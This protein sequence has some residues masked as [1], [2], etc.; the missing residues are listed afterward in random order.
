MQLVGLSISAEKTGAVSARVPFYGTTVSEA[1]G[2]MSA[3]FLGLQR[4]GFDIRQEQDGKFV[5]TGTYEGVMDDTGGG[6]TY[7]SEERTVYD[8]SPSFEQADIRT[9]PKFSELLKKYYGTLDENEEVTWGKYI[10]QGTGSGG[11]LGGSGDSTNFI[12]NPMR[13]VREYY[14][15][16]GVWSQKRVYPNLPQ[17]VFSSVGKIIDNPPGDL[18]SIGTRFWLTLP[19]VVTQKG[20]QWEVTRRWMMSGEKSTGAKEAAKDIYEQFNG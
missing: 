10:P 8:W 13:G 12:D 16:G 7:D 4:T 3:R 1:F 17:D 14:A 9:H 6:A 20:Q 5:A 15:L 11:G 19:P 2:N 18:P